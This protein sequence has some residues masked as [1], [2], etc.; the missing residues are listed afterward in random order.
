[1][2]K[3]LKKEV[4]NLKLLYRATRDGFT[5]AAFHSKCDGKAETISVV[6]SQ[7]GKKIFGGYLDKKWE[8]KEAWIHSD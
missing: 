2:K 8:T 4:L 3:W 6:K 5:G 1:L 7:N